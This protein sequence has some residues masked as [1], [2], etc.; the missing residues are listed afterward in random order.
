MEWGKKFQ[1]FA[2]VRQQKLENLTERYKDQLEILNQKLDRAVE[3]ATIKPVA[4]LKE[5]QTQEK[6]FAINERVEEAQNF[7]KELKNLE[8]AEA[9]RVHGLRQDN[10]EK[11]RNKL[12]GQYKKDL[13]QLQAKMNTQE[14]NL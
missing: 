5:Y 13:Q 4:Q 6:L 12:I 2:Q 1:E 11:Q 3:A 9:N 8:V 7:R 14:H 10:A